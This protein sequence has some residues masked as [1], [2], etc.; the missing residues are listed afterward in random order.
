[1]NHYYNLS[2]VDT[3][4]ELNF[5]TSRKR[6]VGGISKRGD[7]HG[8]CIISVAIRRLYQAII[9]V[10]LQVLGTAEKEESIGFGMN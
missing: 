6:W 8:V 7:K 5:G 2:V 1:V 10:V 9:N 4:G 3:V